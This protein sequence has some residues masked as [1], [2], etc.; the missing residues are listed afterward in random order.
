MSQG[1]TYTADLKMGYYMKVPP[2]TLFFGQLVA[3][4]WSCF[5]QVGVVSASI[6]RE[7]HAEC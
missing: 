1:L 6:D 3:S 5:V 2:R 4:V 7:Q